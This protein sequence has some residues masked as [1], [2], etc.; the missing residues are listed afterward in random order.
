MYSSGHYQ[1]TNW[2]V[3]LSYDNFNGEPIEYH[4]RRRWLRDAK[5]R[6]CS[7]I[8]GTRKMKAYNFDGE[9]VG[10]FITKLHRG[11]LNAKS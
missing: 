7:I 3:S 1:C 2:G 10:E 4:D 6:G 11:W 5:R 9:I 8:K